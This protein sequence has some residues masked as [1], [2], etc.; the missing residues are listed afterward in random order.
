MAHVFQTSKLNRIWINLIVDSLAIFTFLASERSERD[1]YR[2][3]NEKIGDVC[4][5]IFY[6]YIISG[7]LGKGTLWRKN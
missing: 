2:G 1:T 7:C 3:K 5:F 6:L 4:L